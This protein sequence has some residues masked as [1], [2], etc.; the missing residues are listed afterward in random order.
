MEP[1][2]TPPVVGASSK[3]DAGL[4]EGTAIVSLAFAPGFPVPAA[5]LPS[6]LR[7]SRCA[8]ANLA[9]GRAAPN[10]AG[11]SAPSDGRAAGAHASH[12]CSRAAAA[13]SAR[14]APSG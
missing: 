4:F 5:P 8:T 1:P 12:A 6:G 2:I 10:S 13:S 7:R 9:S 14:G 3:P 11:G